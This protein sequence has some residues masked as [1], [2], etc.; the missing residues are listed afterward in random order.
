M[1]NYIYQLK[2]KRQWGGASTFSS[3]SVVAS[4]ARAIVF[5]TPSAVWRCV[6]GRWS[7]AC[8]SVY[9]WGA[10]TGAATDLWLLP[11]RVWRRF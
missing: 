1:T 5:R 10:G 2:T 4:Q 6:N 11:G 8:A 7:C 3:S 9:V